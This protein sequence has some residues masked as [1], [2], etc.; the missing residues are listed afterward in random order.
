M[1]M[2]VGVI[3]VTVM[4]EYCAHEEAPDWLAI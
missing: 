3:S 4:I 2:I 1:G